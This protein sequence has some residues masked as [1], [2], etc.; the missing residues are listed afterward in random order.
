MR[1]SF[2][3]RNRRLRHVKGLCELLLCQMAVGAQFMQRHL[4]EIL[5]GEALKA[6]ARARELH[7]YPKILSSFG[8]SLL[9]RR[10]KRASLS[11]GAAGK[12]YVAARIGREP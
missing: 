1:A 7:V 11:P 8:A 12:L 10:A 4:F 3:L 2:Q 5:V 6:Q 9:A